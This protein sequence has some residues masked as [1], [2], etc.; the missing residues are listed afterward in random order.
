MVLC[1]NLI[2]SIWHIHMF[3]VITWNFRF[4]LVCWFIIFISVTFKLAMS[5]GW[6]VCGRSSAEKNQRNNLTSTKNVIDLDESGIGIILDWSWCNYL[7]T[8]LCVRCF[9]I[10]KE[11]S[12]RLSNKEG[13]FGDL[14]VEEIN[15]WKTEWIKYEQN[16]IIAS[17]S[18]TKIKNSYSLFCDI[19]CIL[20]VKTRIWNIESFSY[21]FSSS[22]MKKWTLH[23]V[24]CFKITRSCL[25]YYTEFG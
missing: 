6:D 3:N 7:G 16:Y 1:S 18:F 13:Q 5:K 9:T 24:F 14:T 25:P 22:L 17:E 23:K 20:K 15:C 11:H 21:D 2:W 4:R 19:E 12:F 8:F 10:C